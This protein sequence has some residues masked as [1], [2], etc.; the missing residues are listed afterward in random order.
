MFK[1]TPV[2]NGFSTG[3]IKKAK[4]FYG[5]TLGFTV[6]ENEGGILTL[7]FTGGGKTFV[8]PKPNHQPA[9][10]T[11]MNIMV[12][13]IEEAVDGLLS[14]GVA[15]EHYDGDIHTDEKGIAWGKKVNMGPNI[16][17]FKDPAG[18]ILSLLEA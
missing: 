4:D 3:D 9:T 15:F 8:Y 14:K 13:D 7:H 18:N 17:W 1:D 16:A 5:G 10:F 2:I 12:E 11:I 6:E